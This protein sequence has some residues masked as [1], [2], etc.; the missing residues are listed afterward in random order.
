MSKVRF[1]LNKKGVRELLQSQDMQKVIDRYAYQVQSR[2][3][4]GY[5]VESYTGF[6]RA[7]AIVYAATAKA[8]KDN[9]E[10]NTLLKAR[11]G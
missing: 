11:G 6:D 7:H 9:Y 1:E 4:D 3:G 10:N 2:A 8:R 5:E